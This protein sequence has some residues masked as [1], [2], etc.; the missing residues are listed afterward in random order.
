MLVT[1]HLFEAYLKCHT[2]CFL[3]SLGETGTG[4]GYSDWVQAQQASY[5]KS[6]VNIFLS[7]IRKMMCALARRRDFWIWRLTK[8]AEDEGHPALLLDATNTH[9]F[10]GRCVWVES[11]K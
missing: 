10:W 6:S 7:F 5:R 11:S 3:L 1:S 4:N 8:G 2:K 9:L